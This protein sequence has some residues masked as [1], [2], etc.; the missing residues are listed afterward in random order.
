MGVHED[1]RLFVRVGIPNSQQCGNLITCSLREQ[2]RHLGRVEFGEPH[3]SKAE[4]GGLQKDMHPVYEKCSAVVLPTWHEGMSN[5]LMES[6]ACG[7]P[8]IAS[9]ISGCREIFENGVTGF[10]FAPKSSQDLIRAL[11]EFL[12]MSR[13]ER[14]VMGE[15]AR[16][17]M[18]RE[19]DRKK[20]TA[21]YMEEIGK[22]V[23]N[24]KA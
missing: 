3:Y 9:S 8:V 16:R 24:G 7:R 20:V 11:R 19:F 2:L 15:S 4:I 6:S 14:A 1:T 23:K 5:V 21:A 17:K 10:G 22:A 18:E 13:S 12:R